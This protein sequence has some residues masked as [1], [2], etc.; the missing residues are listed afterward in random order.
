MT[1]DQ[2]KVLEELIANDQYPERGEIEFITEGFYRGFFMRK[3][4]DSHEMWYVDGQLAS[5]INCKDDRWEGL[6]EQCHENG[7]MSARGE[8]KEGK[9]EGLHEEWYDNGQLAVRWNFKHGEAEGLCERWSANGQLDLRVNYKNDRLNGLWEKWNE[10]GQLVDRRRYKNNKLTRYLPL[11]D[12][13]TPK[14]IKIQYS[15]KKGGAKL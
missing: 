5:R 15:K 9:R 4:P 3:T 6:L 8:Y 2:K 12:K 13:E 10:N 7:Q 11:D 1:K 14:Q